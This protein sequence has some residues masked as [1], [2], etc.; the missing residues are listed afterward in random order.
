[1]KY[2]GVLILLIVT[3]CANSQ[4]Q[5]PVSTEKTVI[6]TLAR[7]TLTPDFIVV[8]H[9]VTVTP[10][11]LMAE[12]CFKS[13]VTQGDL[14]GCANKEREL[15]KANL[16]KLVS[17]IR[18]TPEEKQNFDQLQVEW[19]A[20]VEKDCSFLYGQV[21]ATADGNLY[22]QRGSMAPM[23]RGLCEAKHYKE[24]IEDLKLAYF[25]K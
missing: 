22:Y 13:A 12:D 21:I 14:N 5:L 6:P 17:K 2:W 9:V 25:D 23:L 18:F 16:E 20:F 8:T 15:A 10:E 7:Y 3:A 24:R 19:E 4:S 11:S 1:M